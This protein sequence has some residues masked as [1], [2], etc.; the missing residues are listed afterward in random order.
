MAMNLDIS[1]V[2]L[3]TKKPQAKYFLPA[4]MHFTEVLFCPQPAP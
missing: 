1:H 4:V 3:N 2:K